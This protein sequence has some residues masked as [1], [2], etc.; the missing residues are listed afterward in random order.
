[1][2]YK[3]PGAYLTVIEEAAPAVTAAPAMIPLIIG[4]SAKYRAATTSFVRGAGDNSDYDIVDLPTNSA[5]PRKDIISLGYYAK[6]AN[7]TQGYFYKTTEDGREPT[8]EIFEDIPQLDKD[9]SFNAKDLIDERHFIG[10]YVLVKTYEGQYAIYWTS[11]GSAKVSLDISLI[12]TYRTLFG[13]DDQRNPYF[14]PRRLAD[15]TDVEAYCGELWN[16]YDGENATDLLNDANDAQRKVS[17]LALG[18][19]IAL[20]QG[21]NEVYAL[22]VP[23]ST[24]QDGGRLADN[25]ERALDEYAAFLNDAWR[26]VPMDCDMLIFDEDTPIADDIGREDTANGDCFRQINNAVIRHIRKCSS[27]EERKERTAIFGFPARFDTDGHTLVPPSSYDGPYLEKDGRTF[28]RMLTDYATSLDYGRVSL[29]YPCTCRFEVPDWKIV[30]IGPQYLAAAY[31]GV[32]Y[33]MPGYLPKTRADFA[34]FTSI[35]GIGE[36]TGVRLTRRQLN[37]LADYGIMLIVQDDATSPIVIR[38][39]LTTSQSG[40]LRQTENSIIAIKDYVTKVLRTMC[41]RYVGRFNITT[42]LITRLRGSLDSSLAS[43]EGDGWIIQGEITSIEQDE[44]Q[45]DT[46]LVTARIYVPYPCNYIDITLY[47]E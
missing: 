1:M 14:Q 31:A 29:V 8:D 34:G 12:L 17:P 32:E 19:Y 43:L 20:L 27:Y 47:V 45:K 4:T 22:R 35:T 21:A 23:E 42:D 16:M 3:E 15:A 10:D 40:D 38:H 28:F 36:S 41:E 33:R 24:G 46:L 5:D 44:V 37:E 2:A 26:I 7:F 25:Y 6:A 11:T 18:C 30:D 9:G 13:V 39:Q